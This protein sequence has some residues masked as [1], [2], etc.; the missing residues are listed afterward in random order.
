MDF[1]EDGHVGITANTSLPYLQLLACPLQHVSVSRVSLEKLLQLSR[2]QQLLLQI[3]R[4]G[5]G[6][7]AFC[8]APPHVLNSVAE[9]LHVLQLQRQRRKR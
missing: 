6:N 7:G 1:V 5:G 8:D 9:A 4:N 2:I 3:A